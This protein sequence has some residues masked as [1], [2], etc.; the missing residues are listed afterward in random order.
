MELDDTEF[1]FIVAGTNLVECVLSGA[2]ARAGKKVLHLEDEEWYGGH[3]WATLALHECR[4]WAERR[5]AE[6]HLRA[7]SFEALGRSRDY[8]L[9]LLPVPILAAGPLVALLLRSSIGRYLEFKV[10][11]TAYLFTDGAL[12]PVPCSKGDVFKSK[13]LAKK[14]KGQLMSFMRWVLEAT[15]DDGH[16][17]DGLNPDGVI[18]YWDRPFADFLSARNFPEDLQQFIR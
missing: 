17:L 4:Q 13:V 9:D 7:S 14:Q 10:V 8:S 11:D 12:Q 3:Q 18:E 16:L 15:D 6:Q 5:G 1:D 2:L